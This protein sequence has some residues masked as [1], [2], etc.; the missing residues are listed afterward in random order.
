MSS[1]PADTRTEVLDYLFKHSPALVTE[2][3]EHLGLTA[4]GVRRHI[5]HLLEDGLIEET[6]AKEEADGRR[7]RGRPARAYQLSPKGRD[8]FG[9]N[10]DS[11]AT[12]ALREVMELGG[13]EALDNFANKRI[14]AIIGDLKLGE[15]DTEEAVRALVDRLNH[16]GY[17]GEVTRDGS[18]V[19]ICQFQCPI[20]S[21]AKEFPQL[22]AAEHRAMSEAL[23]TD[24]QIKS[25]IVEGEHMCLTRI[26]IRDVSKKSEV[27]EKDA[28]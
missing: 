16:N 4:P 3:S 2:I 15:L 27:L 28:S 8:S 12:L 24:L 14:H 9:H 19:Q 13:E 17:A 22:C 11:L 1:Q 6:A 25:S 18:C 26:P 7:R 10:Y 23:Q 21:A 20:F 5:D